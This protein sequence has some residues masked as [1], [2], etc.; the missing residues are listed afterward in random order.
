MRKFLLTLLGFFAV[1]LV[2]MILL[3][4][5]PR[6]R[7]DWSTKNTDALLYIMTDNEQ[8][9]FVLLGTPTARSST[10]AVTMKWRG[11]LANTS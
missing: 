8:Y 11:C 1:N 7:F 3:A 9:D 6:Y 10:A 2:L 5:Y 4:E